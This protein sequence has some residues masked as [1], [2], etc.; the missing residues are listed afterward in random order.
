MS[1]PSTRAWNP[2]SHNL[3]VHV[4]RDYAPI[5]MAASKND[6]NGLVPLYHF[7]VILRKFSLLYRRLQSVFTRVKMRRSEIH[8]TLETLNTY[9]VN[10]EAGLMRSLK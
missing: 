9:K 8:F 2:S 5:D 4:H 7:A 1:T 6:T 3:A 10:S